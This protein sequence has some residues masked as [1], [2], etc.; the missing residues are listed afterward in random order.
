MH[1]NNNNTIAGRTRSKKALA[2]VNHPKNDVVA[3]SSDDDDGGD[4]GTTTVGVQESQTTTDALPECGVKRG[5]AKRKVVR[6]VESD[7]EVKVNLTRRRKFGLD[8]L[9][10]EKSNVESAE[11]ETGTSD[12]PARRT[13][14]HFRGS[15]KLKLGGTLNQPICLD[16]EEEEEGGGDGDGVLESGEEGAKTC[17]GGGWSDEEG[18]ESESEEEMDDD[19]IWRS[20]KCSANRR[21]K[22]GGERLKG[23]GSVCESEKERGGSSWRKGSAIQRNKRTPELNK[24]VDSPKTVKKLFNTQRENPQPEEKSEE[25]KELEALWIE[26][27]YC[28]SLIQDNN[29]S[30]SEVKLFYFFICGF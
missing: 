17:M 26:S 15:K 25:E 7:G 11:E 13:R 19:P 22:H 12:G 6:I 20:W 10:D 29:A 3:L 28:F 27:D 9:I 4:D 2:P 16:G 30:P 24:G 8:V 18:E 1:R 5:R 21:N 23:D 14:S